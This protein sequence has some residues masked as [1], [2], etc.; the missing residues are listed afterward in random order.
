MSCSW[1][2]G[3]PPATLEC[4]QTKQQLSTWSKLSPW[5]SIGALHALHAHAVRY[6]KHSSPLFI[7]GISYGAKLAALLSAVSPSL[8]VPSH[9]AAEQTA[10]NTQWSG[11]A[12][13]LG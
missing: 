9:A 2:L 5:C 3:S 13:A 6:N 8:S 7:A 1:A 10:D 12:L 4:P 11:A